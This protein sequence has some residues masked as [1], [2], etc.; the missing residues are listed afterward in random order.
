MNHDTAQ[1]RMSAVGVALPAPRAQY[2][3]ATKDQAW[4]Q[5]AGQSYAGV[6]AAAPP[7]GNARRRRLIAS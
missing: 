4:R 1:K 3:D 6:L 2:L 7:T 5:D